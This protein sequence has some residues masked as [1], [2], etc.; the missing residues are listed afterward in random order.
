ML[1]ALPPVAV[2]APPRDPFFDNAKLLVIVLVVLGHAWEPLVGLPGERPLR[3]AYLLVYLFHMPVF[4]LVSGW[5]SQSFRGE[6]RQLRRLLTGVLAPFLLWNTLL[7]LWVQ[8]LA[9]TR[10]ALAPLTPTWVLW[11]LMSLFLWRITAPLWRLVR[12]P[13][14]VALAVFLLSGAFTFGPMLSLA[15]TLE[16]LPYFVIGLCLRREHLDRLL[17]LRHVRLYAAAAF[18]AVAALAWAAAPST[19]VNWL[20]RSGSSGSLHVSY[21]RWL[22]ESSVVF[23]LGLLLTAAFLAL[24]PRRATWFSGLGAGTMYAFLLHPFLQRALLLKGW[25]RWS[26]LHHPG[27][28]LLLTAGAVALALLLCTAPVRRL[29]RPLV[30]PRLGRLLR[31]EPEQPVQSGAQIRP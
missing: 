17:A 26:F 13:V 12:W 30:E 22:A 16:F 7:T 19:D 28:W 29:L 5:F 27:G 15:R 21:A 24:V 23:L 31:P 9:G 10:L 2:E 3:A 14:P 1:L 6:P 8:W 18:A 20:Y 4:V 25:Y 11:F